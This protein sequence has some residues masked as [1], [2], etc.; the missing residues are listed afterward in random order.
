[1]KALD[2]DTPR[3]DITPLAKLTLE[4][5]EV[6]SRFGL[7]FTPVAN[8]LGP[9]TLALA[10]LSTGT[11]VG[12][13]RLEHDRVPGVD[14]YQFTDRRPR[15][16]LAELLYETGLTHDDVSWVNGG[17]SEEDYLLWA[18]TYAEA[19]LYILLHVPVGDPAP[20]PVV[21]KDIDVAG[22]GAI[23]R[24][25]DIEVHVRGRAR[26]FPGWGIGN[27]VYSYP[28]DAPS[29]II[30]AG[31][32]W[33]VAHRIA[34]E[35]KVLLET[36]GAPPLDAQQ[37]ATVL[38]C[39]HAAANTAEEVL[40][41]L[42]ADAEQ[43]PVRAFWTPFGQAVLRQKPAVFFGRDSLEAVAHEYREAVTAFERLYGPTSTG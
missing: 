30:D 15:E 36:Y 33:W 29:T 18:R 26:N 12:F 20:D 37:Y 28:D 16:V 27:R 8:D 25:R 38:D 22:D 11:I 2:A 34:E 9:A 41:F 7:R 39:L 5:A 3:D 42:P 31:T 14:V 40:K 23:V 35:I 19:H 6:E 4:P 24:H 21:E 17:L 43:V 13:A 10:R 32:W 1:V